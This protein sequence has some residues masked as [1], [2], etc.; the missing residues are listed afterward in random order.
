M[1]N[2][3]CMAL[4]SLFLIKGC[5]SEANKDKSLGECKEVKE[6]ISDIRPNYIPSGYYTS[7]ESKNY[8]QLV[9]KKILLISD[10][11]DGYYNLEYSESTL[12]IRED[13]KNI[14]YL[15]FM[16]KKGVRNGNACYASKEALQ[17]YVFE[18]NGNPVLFSEGY[19]S[20][21]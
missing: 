7:M 6:S 21:K 3:C 17:V 19:E 4:T 13:D 16:I 2:I 1:R 20:I 12:Y 9:N 18:E 15:K 14:G 10:K 8:F 11:Y 5:F